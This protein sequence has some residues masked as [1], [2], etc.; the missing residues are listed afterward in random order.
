MSSSLGG[1][2][3]EQQVFH[4]RPLFHLA[5]STP[6]AGRALHDRLKLLL[7]YHATYIAPSATPTDSVLPI[8]SRIL[9]DR[10]VERVLTEG[11]VIASTRAK[12]TSTSDT[13]DVDHPEGAAEDDQ[14]LATELQSLYGTSDHPAKSFRIPHSS[15]PRDGHG[16]L[17]VPGWVLLRASEILFEEEAHSEC[18]TVSSIVLAT[19]LKVSFAICFTMAKAEI[20]LPVD[21]RQTMISSVLVVG[22]TA[23][24]PNFIPRLRDNL[25]EALQ[26]ETPR[27][28]TMSLAQWKK[29][30]Q[31]PYR[32]LYG[33]LPKVAILND[34][35]SVDSRSGTAPRWTP[36]LMAWVGGSLAGYVFLIV[37]KASS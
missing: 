28:G 13:M 29:R 37:W 2:R 26:T 35:K 33:L 23:S 17:T 16:T 22:G 7:R 24:L 11:C 19:L 27:D 8:P 15:S 30:N 21:L 18:V 1:I 3:A 6:L 9:T 31:E 14:R 5:R 10:V 25:A 36:S 20:Q 4:S 12:Q 32:E 34:P